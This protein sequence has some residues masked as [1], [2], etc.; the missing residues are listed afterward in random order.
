[1]KQVIKTKVKKVMEENNKK[2]MK[3]TELM[4][5]IRVLKIENERVNDEGSKGS[6]EE[7][8]YWI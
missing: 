3:V 5:Q 7:I 6:K 4:E 2:D 8:N 1:M